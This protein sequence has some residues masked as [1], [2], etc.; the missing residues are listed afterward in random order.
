M[1]MDIDQFYV[2]EDGS[3]ILVD[4]CGN[5]TYCDTTRFKVVT[6]SEDRETPQPKMGQWIFHKPFDIGHKNCNECIECSQCH[7]WL[8]YDCYAKTPYCLNCG[9]KMIEPQESEGKECHQT[10]QY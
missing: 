4:E 8:G 1:R 9:A 6:E 5:I 10:K 3:L 2:G 7:T